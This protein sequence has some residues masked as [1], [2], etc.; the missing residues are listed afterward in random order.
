MNNKIIK[1]LIADDDSEFLN[2]LFNHL[3]KEAYTVFKASNGIDAIAI[4]KKE[5]PQLIILDIN[6]PGMDG[7][8]VC[9][10]IKEYPELNNSII[11]FLTNCNEDYTQIAAFEAG[12]DDYITKPLKPE[13]HLSRIRAILKRIVTV[14][15]EPV[16]VIGD[17]TIDREKFLVFLKNKRIELPR[18]EF[19]LLEYLTSRPG[20]VFSRDEILNSLWNKDFTVIHRTIDVHISKLREKI[21]DKYIKTIKGI[22]Y[23]F[24]M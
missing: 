15:Q 10:H 14:N 21:G 9:R 2:I 23:K 22:G 17:I 4:A 13:L 8:E 3:K 7:V 20:K 18:K 1:V 19:E 6:M 11:L 24:E 12:A 5:N 16:T